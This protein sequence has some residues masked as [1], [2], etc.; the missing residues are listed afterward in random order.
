MLWSSWRPLTFVVDVG[1]DLDVALLRVH[2]Q[3]VEVLVLLQEEVSAQLHAVPVLVHRV[4]QHG[5]V[6][7]KLAGRPRAFQNKMLHLS[8]ADLPT[9]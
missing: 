9:F 8:S 6:V 3:V 2:R 4:D 5:V 7:I 1:G